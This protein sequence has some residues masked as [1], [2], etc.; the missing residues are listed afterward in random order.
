MKDIGKRTPINFTLSLRTYNVKQIQ[1]LMKYLTKHEFSFRYKVYYEDSK[2]VHELKVDMHWIHNLRC[3]F[4]VLRNY[5]DIMI[6]DYKPSKKEKRKQ[7]NKMEFP[8][9]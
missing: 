6:E 7:K 2:T 8:L 4:H 5:D 9:T 1:P 3:V